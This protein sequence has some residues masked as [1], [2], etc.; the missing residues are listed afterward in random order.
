MAMTDYPYST[1]FLQPMPANPVNVACSM[2]NPLDD[3][4]T[5]AQVLVA[6][7][8]AA[9]VYYNFTGNQTC[10]DVDGTSSSATVGAN[11]WDYLSCSTLVM[12]ISSD[13]INDMFLP[14][15]FSIQAINQYCATTW[16]VAPITNYVPIFYG[17]DT[18][19][20]NPLRYATNICFSNGSLDPWQS[21]SVVASLK[22]NSV[23]AFVMQGAAHHLDLRAPN[24]ADPQS[25]TVG[26]LTEK[27]LI[28]YWLNGQK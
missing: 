4:A 25:V 14:Q 17:A 7:Y 12:P 23:V 13:R 15:P 26:R 21:G 18:N 3:N 16:G 8:N 10:S 27:A 11:G 24:A 2:F 9:N 28:Q 22:S 20:A 1:N 19:P 5:D 6:L